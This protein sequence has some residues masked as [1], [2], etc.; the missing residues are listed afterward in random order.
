MIDVSQ[1]E[2]SFAAL[3]VLR[4][5]DLHVQPGQF[6]VLLGANGCGKSTLIRC[7]NGLT[8][9]D[10][11]RIEVAGV[12]ISAARR[13]RLRRA[14]RQI[15]VV[16]Q[17]FNLVPNVSAFQNVLYGALGRPSGGLM[18]TLPA[19]APSQLREQA[20]ACLERVGLVDHAATAARDLSGGQQQ[21]VAIAR[22][23][24]QSPNVLIADEP[25][26]SLDP[27]AGRA[28]MELLIEIVAERGMTV[29]CSLHQLEFAMA[30]GD[31]V[32]GM[33]AGRIELNECRE[34]V[35]RDAMGELYKGVV[36][37]DHETNNAQV[38]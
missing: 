37:V 5:I 3:H 10:A 38:H 35:N 17:Q 18:R 21:R 20:M 16:F 29:L 15:G 14:R 33:K 19:F 22:T 9:P 27:Q 26:A 6:V 30:Y 11:G 13:R 12:Q 4:G 25:V 31:R 32:V 28:V 24:L 23:L 7:L 36:R 34:R 1:V 8:R 2:K